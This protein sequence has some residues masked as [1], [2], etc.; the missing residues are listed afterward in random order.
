[1]GRNRS[2]LLENS[3]YFGAFRLLSYTINS[4]E[5]FVLPATLSGINTPSGG[6]Q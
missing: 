4:I 3:S 1:M 2:E 6:P 5:H